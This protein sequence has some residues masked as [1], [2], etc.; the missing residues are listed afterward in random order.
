MRGFVR[1]VFPD[2][3]MKLFFF[4]FSLA[5]NLKITNI[6]AKQLCVSID[7]VIMTPDTNQS[8]GPSWIQSIQDLGSRIFSR[9]GVHNDSVSS[10]YH[11]ATSSGTD[12]GQPSRKRKRLAETS[13]TEGRPQKRVTRSSRDK[14]QVCDEEFKT[15]TLTI[16]DCSLSYICFDCLTNSISVSLGEQ[17]IPRCPGAGCNSFIKSDVAIAANVEHD[18]Q[19]TG[20]NIEET[21]GIK[22][23]GLAIICG[24]GKCRALMQV[25]RSCCRARMS[26]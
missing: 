20:K 13:N 12:A 6:Q 2:L 25:R 18:M 4:L 8:H 24:V 23:S 15:I 17:R 26:D 19:Q 9:A 14:C 5:S 10:Q 11:T 3:L 22:A 1:R 16:Q 7:R 21:D